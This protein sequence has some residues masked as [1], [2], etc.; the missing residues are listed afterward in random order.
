MATWMRNPETGGVWACPDPLVSLYER[1]GWETTDDPEAVDEELLPRPVSAAD[2][3]DEQT[4]FD[5]NDHTA[6]E[7]NE[8]L[9]PLRETSPGEVDRVLLLERQGKNRKSITGD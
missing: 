1:R 9:D 2:P 6:D 5:P 3:A 4:G 7:V 8:Y